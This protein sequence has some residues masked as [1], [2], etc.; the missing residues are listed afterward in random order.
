MK[1]KTGQ[2]EQGNLTGNSKNSHE[3][4]QRKQ[5]TNKRDTKTGYKTLQDDPEDRKSEQGEYGHVRQINNKAE[6]CIMVKLLLLNEADGK[7]EGKKGYNSAKRKYEAR[8]HLTLTQQRCR[9][10]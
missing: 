5:R 3:K 10:S 9:G 1:H 2:R 6:N 4:E 7:H 8:D